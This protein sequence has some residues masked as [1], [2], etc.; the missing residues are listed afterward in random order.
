[1]EIPAKTI[2]QV[3]LNKLSK[4]EDKDKSLFN[5]WS[6]RYQKEMENP[7]L[8]RVAK[9]YGSAALEGIAPRLLPA[10]KLQG[11][12]GVAD[13]ERWKE[14]A[15][16]VS[17]APIFPGVHMGPK[18]K[19]IPRPLELMHRTWQAFGGLTGPASGLAAEYGLGVA[20]PQ[21]QAEIIKRISRTGLQGE[22]EIVKDI[23]FNRHK[24]AEVGSLITNLLS[25]KISPRQFAGQLI[26]VQ[27][28]KAF[29][30]QLISK[31]QL[32]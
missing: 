7:W 2:A 8:H 3:K 18:V 21:K 32:C 23:V 26:E 4:K 13:M 9:Q 30:D 5:K 1:M 24:A 14:S 20:S 19:D 15:K 6:E 29:W 12:E 27:E 25:R 22:K 16:M 17:Q 31:Y 10:L 28:S 11:L